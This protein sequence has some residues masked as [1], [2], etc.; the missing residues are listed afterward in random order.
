LRRIFVE[1]TSAGHRARR[2]HVDG[3]E[4]RRLIKESWVTTVTGSNR[5]AGAISSFPDAGIE[6]TSSKQNGF[7][8]TGSDLSPTGIFIVKPK[9]DF[10]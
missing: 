9:P 4:N 5:A 10:F 8:T 1:Q 7:S 2:R 6:K 3:A